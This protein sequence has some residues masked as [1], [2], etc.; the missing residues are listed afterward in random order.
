MAA[1]QV[2]Q[3][4]ARQA[5]SCDAMG[6]PLTAMLC[7]V[8]AERLDLTTRFG[9]TILEWPGD[10]F[11]DNVALRACGALHA[12]K[13]TGWEPELVAVYPPTT[14]TPHMLAVALIDVLQHHDGFLTARLASPPQTN[15]VA[16]SSTLLGAMLHVAERTKLPLELYEIGASAGLNLSF[17]RYRYRLGAGKTWGPAD[18]PLAIETDWRG[19]VPPLGAPLV[20]LRRGGCDL[21]PIDP[22]N[23]EDRERLL[24]YVWAD[25]THRLERVETALGIAATERVRVEQAD[26][27]DWL[28]QIVAAPPERGRARVIFHTVVWQYIPTAVRARIEASLARL[29]EGAVPDAPV[30]HIAMEADGQPDARVELTIWPGGET[31]LLGR[32]DFHGRWTAWA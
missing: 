15:E 18:A 32:A 28:A 14:P 19:A 29:A 3:Q 24:S 2:L 20:V 12:L 1:G 25:Q 23:A 4:F 6:S 26:A 31:R 27:A 5:E 9:R 17:D 10:P 21:R 16:R 8:L 11:D 13:R 7:R 22:A 30:A